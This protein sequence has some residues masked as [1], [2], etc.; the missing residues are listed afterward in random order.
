MTI[1]D[2]MRLHCNRV[3]RQNVIF[4]FIDT[5]SMQDVT[6]KVFFDGGDKWDSIVTEWYDKV[7]EE[8]TYFYSDNNI[9]IRIEV[10]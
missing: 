1:E 3:F 7:I 4:R 9:I 2:F 8:I 5:N 6:K 10:E